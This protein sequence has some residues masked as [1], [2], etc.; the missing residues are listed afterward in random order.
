LSNQ[1]DASSSSLGYFYQ[2]L[3]ALYAL[4]KSGGNSSISIEK[5]DDIVVE[6]ENA[7]ELLQLK[8]IKSTGSSLGNSS[9]NLWKTIRIWADWINSSEGSSN[10]RFYFVTTAQASKNSVLYYLYPQESKK[11]NESKALGIMNQVS[12][13][14]TNQDLVAAFKIYSSLTQAEKKTL[15][16]KIIVIDGSPDYQ[17]VENAIIE[18][19]CFSA[20]EE[21]VDYLKNDLT[22]WWY[23]KVAQVLVNENVEQISFSEL[24]SHISD[25]RE[26]YHR[27]N[28][29][30]HFR[31]TEVPEEDE[32]AEGEKIFIEQLRLV[33]IRNPRVKQ[34]I[35]DY[36]RAFIQ[37]TKWV[38][39]S[40]ISKSDLDTYDKVLQ[41]EWERV[42]E[43]MLE[44]LGTETL[45][46][47]QKVTA[48][49]ELYNDLQKRVDLNI[50]ERCIEAYVMRGSFHILANELNIGWHPEFR[51]RLM[52]LYEQVF[53]VGNERVE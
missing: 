4:M 23:S 53:G 45:E 40:L 50:K 14:S 24:Q 6:K 32:L 2:S 41:D 21:H 34:A 33:S 48:G 5:L 46:E 11:R 36:Y 26:Q 3:Y 20:R 28:L 38:D 49:R 27:D 1:F 29:P 19:L 9:T 42:H 39:D 35:G 15:L 30:I 37:R 17:Q 31:D 10:D 22:G 8:H 13:T 25:A 47:S 51:D 7:R 18:S 12:T 16:S 52:H 43:E 44:D